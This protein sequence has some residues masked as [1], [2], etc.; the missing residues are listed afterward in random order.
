MFDLR[1]IDY[2]AEWDQATL[3]DLG[4]LVTGRTPPGSREEFFGG[5]T[6]FVTP[7]DMDGRRYIDAT[8]RQLSP[9]GK[10]L[11]AGVLVPAASVVVSCIGSQLGKAALVRQEAATNQQINTLVPSERLDSR[12]AYYVLATQQPYLQAITSGSA[13]P[14]V[15]KTTFGRVSIPLPPL[16][17]QRRI[18]AILGA[19]DDKIDLNRKMNKT[20]EEMAQAIF[21]SWFID[22]DGHTDFVDSELG[23][24]PKGWST[25]PVSECVEALFDGPHATPKE[26][27]EGPVFLGIKNLTG[28]GLNLSDLKRL[29][30]LDWP[31]WTKRVVPRHGD[32]VFCYEARLGDFA[33]LPPGLRCCLGRRL[34]LVRPDAGRNNLHFLFHFFV[35]QP[36]QTFLRAHVN[37][38]STV[39]RILLNDFP[40]YPV[41]CPPDVLVQRFEAVARPIWSRI[42]T[43]QTESSTLTELRDTLLPKLISGELR[44][45]EAE[46]AVEAV[47]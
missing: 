5:E 28:T 24:I 13:Q 43:G 30:E 39:D 41:L 23:R 22:F 42:H 37:P 25:K 31:R 12:Y 32:I 33:I 6:L 18:A 45:P 16:D 46:K 44:V 4:R 26:S 21:K 19:L 3:S 8:S 35:G 38:G 34:A 2:P 29:S 11:L 15:N 47:A 20:L 27:A 7:S 36:F 9:K 40:D 14:I 17:E 1:N 10:E